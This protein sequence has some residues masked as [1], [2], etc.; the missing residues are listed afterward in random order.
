MTIVNWN[1]SQYDNWHDYVSMHGQDVIEWLQPQSEERIIDIGCGTG[2]LTNHIA[3]AGAVVSGIDYSPEMIAQALTKYPQLRFN[4]VD[5]HHF[6]SEPPVDAVFSNAA[7]HWMT[8]P[9]D[10][11]AS[12]WNV[13]RPGGRF[14]AEFGGIGNIATVQTAIHTVLQAGRQ[15]TKVNNPWYFPSIGMYSS[16][17]EQQGFH[18]RRAVLF[19]RP[20][21]LQK[22]TSAFSV[23]LDTFA[24]V[25]FQN[26]SPDKHLAY[27]EQIERIC[28]PKLFDPLKERWIL[29]Y[30]RIRIE[31]IKPL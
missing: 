1:A 30:V 9:A 4:I 25:Y 21:P 31:A 11:I 2:D 15:G 10:V 3:Q 18:V 24:N 8:R 14:V 28:H 5:G 16:Q 23:W 12:V 7:L 27:K 26:I 19:E 29:D 6:T 22:D 13:L 17:L 20:T